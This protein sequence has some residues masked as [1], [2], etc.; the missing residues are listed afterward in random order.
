[1]RRSPG[2]AEAAEEPCCPTADNGGTGMDTGAALSVSARQT[3]REDVGDQQQ[4]QGE[5]SIRRRP[6]GPRAFGDPA[7]WP[8][9]RAIDL[10]DSFFSAS[11]EDGGG[12]GTID[13]GVPMNRVCLGDGAGNAGAGGAA[14]LVG[15]VHTGVGGL[16]M[17]G[18]QRFPGS[19]TRTTTP[20]AGVPPMSPD[21]VSAPSIN[22]GPGT[23]MGDGGAY[24]A[25]AGMGDG[26][27]YKA[28]APGLPS[29]LTRTTTSGAGVPPMS[30]ANVSAPGINPGPES[31]TS[32][33]FWCCL[34]GGQQWCPCF[35]RGG[36]TS[37]PA[38]VVDRSRLAKT[39]RETTNVYKFPTP[40]SSPTVATTASPTLT[41]GPGTT[42][43][44]CTWNSQNRVVVIKDGDRFMCSRNEC[45]RVESLSSAATGDTTSALPSRCAHAE[46][47]VEAER[48]SAPMRQTSVA[49]RASD[50]E[51]ALEKVPGK[52]FNARTTASMRARADQAEKEGLPLLV[53]VGSTKYFA[54]RDGQKFNR[55][56]IGE[57]AHVKYDKSGSKIFQCKASNGSPCS[58]SSSRK[59][60]G[61]CVHAAIV[62]VYIYNQSRSG[63]AGD[64]ME[65]EQDG[66]MDGIEIESEEGVGDGEDVVG[67][68]TGFASYT[69]RQ[70]PQ[71]FREK[72]DQ[73]R[74]I[75]A[76]CR[77]PV[78]EPEFKEGTF[79]RGKI[80]VNACFCTGCGHK[81]EQL[82]D[83]EAI[84]VGQRTNK[85]AELRV[86]TIERKR[87]RRCKLAGWAGDD[88]YE[89][90]VFNYNNN[91]VLE[92]PLLYAIRRVVS[93]GTPVST[94]ARTFLKRLLD[95]VRWLDASDQSRALAS[96]IED[97]NFHT[98]I[99]EAY[100]AFEA[101]TEHVHD[102]TSYQHGRF[103]EV[104]CI[105]GCA[106]IC[107]DD[108][109]TE[110]FE[111]ARVER[112]VDTDLQHQL[113]KL[114]MISKMVFE[115]R[116]RW[117]VE[118]APTVSPHNRISNVMH[119]TAR[120]KLAPEGAPERGDAGEL[121][122]ALGDGAITD[123]NNKTVDDLK[124][125]YRLCYPPGGKGIS[126]YPT[127][128]LL[129][130][131]LEQ[132]WESAGIGDGK[133]CS[134]IF[135][136]KPSGSTAG[137]EGL[138][139]TDGV[140]YALVFQIALE[141]A[142][143]AV[144]IIG[145]RQVPPCM[146]I[147]DIPCMIAP[148]A[149][150]RHPGL[151][152]GGGALPRNVEGQVCLKEL[153]HI[154]ARAYEFPDMHEVRVPPEGF[155]PPT[156]TAF[157]SGAHPAKTVP[158]IYAAFAAGQPRPGVQPH[159]DFRALLN[160]AAEVAE[161]KHEVQTAESTASV[162]RDLSSSPK[163][164]AHLAGVS[165]NSLHK[166]GWHALT[167][168]EVVLLYKLWFQAAACLAPE[169][170]AQGPT[171]TGL[172]L[173]SEPGGAD[174]TPPVRAIRDLRKSELLLIS[175]FLTMV[176]RVATGSTSE[177]TS[178][179]LPDMTLPDFMSDDVLFQSQPDEGAQDNMEE[180][181]GGTSP[182]PVLRDLGVVI[183]VYHQAK[184]DY[185]TNLLQ[186]THPHEAAR[187]YRLI[188]GGVGSGGAE[189]SVKAL[190]IALSGDSLGGEL[191]EDGT[192]SG[193][194]IS[195]NFRR[196]RDFD[197][198]GHFYD[199]K[200][201][202]LW[203]A[204]DGPH[205]GNHQGSCQDRFGGLSRC[206]QITGTNCNTHE[207]NHAKKS[208]FLPSVSGMGFDT[209]TFNITLINEL[210]NTEI[211]RKT[212][213]LAVASATQH[214]HRGDMKKEKQCEQAADCMRDMAAP[215]A[216]LFFQQCEYDMP[217]GLNPAEMGKANGND[218]EFKYFDPKRS[219]CWSRAQEMR[220]VLE[221][222]TDF[223]NSVTNDQGQ[224]RS[225]QQCDDVM[226]EVVE[227]AW[228]EQQKEAAYKKIWTA[229]KERANALKKWNKAV[230]TTQRAKI[231]IPTVPRYEDLA[232]NFK[233]VD[234]HWLPPY[235][236]AWVIYGPVSDNP[237]EDISMTV[238]SGPM[239][240]DD[241]GFDGDN[242]G[243]GGGG[244]GGRDSDD[245]NNIDEDDESISI[246]KPSAGCGKGESSSHS[247]G[248][249]KGKGKKRSAKMEGSG[250]KSSVRSRK[251]LRCLAGP[252]ESLSRQQVKERDRAERKRLEGAGA[253]KNELARLAA[254]NQAAL[255]SVS[256]QVGGMIAHMQA[257][258]AAEQR[259][260]RI[261]ELEKLES[262]YLRL[263]LEDKAKEVGKKLIALL[264]SEPE[265]LG[266][267]NAAGAAGL[268][269]SAALSVPRDCG[270]VD[271]EGD[272][273]SG[274][275]AGG[276]ENLNFEGN[277]GTPHDTTGS[278]NEAAGETSA[279]PAG[280]LSGVA[281]KYFATKNPK[282]GDQ[283][284]AAADKTDDDV[285]VMDAGVEDSAGGGECESEV[286]FGD[287][288]ASSGGASVSLA[289]G[290]GGVGQ[291]AT[292]RDGRARTPPKCRDHGVP[293]VIRPNSKGE[294]VWKCGLPELADQCWFY[295][296]VD[297]GG[298]DADDDDDSDF[299]GAGAAA[300]ARTRETL[301][302]AD[303]A[304]ST[305]PARS[306][307]GGSDVLENT[308]GS[309][310]GAPLIVDGA[311]VGTATTRPA[312]GVASTVRASRGGGRTA[313]G[314]SNLE[315]ASD[316]AAGA[317]QPGASGIGGLAFAAVGQGAT[318][319]DERA[320]TPPKC[321]DH[322]V[323]CVIR[324]N[325]KGED[326]WRCG[327]PA[328]D[329]RC[330][331]YKL[332]DVGGND[333]AADD[334]NGFAGAGA[335]AGA[336]IG[337]SLLA[338]DAASSTAPASSRVAG[339][340]VLENTDVSA[341]G[342]PLVVDDA[343]VGTATTMVRASSGAGRTAGGTSN[344]EGVSG[345][346]AGA[347]QP[348]TTVNSATT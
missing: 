206:P 302:A 235:W 266:G 110:H 252:N 303:A 329:E 258:T 316:V 219:T 257:G 140:L 177:S 6:G 95:D 41:S 339:S 98:V 310:A 54:V 176:L 101:L 86:V 343:V 306:R 12:G 330:W 313:G 190:Q 58:D 133:Q 78:A 123:L 209:F 126:K 117:V 320:R 327:L 326:V 31:V 240:S 217:R 294:D 113:L 93:A 305:A 187:A 89:D 225:G 226:G 227:M 7:W 269:I 242:G 245:E 260:N 213:N 10:S 56:V 67:G 112:D 247:N 121:Y 238:S 285:I 2:G 4:I 115:R 185:I 272:D 25:G 46:V 186:P 124:N 182:T 246:G 107:S 296:R 264:E 191:G 160:R 28:G 82:A 143:D 35:E 286:E 167:L 181:A 129:I 298:S 147:T 61:R 239:D 99:L 321:R 135:V 289:G 348:E 116:L 183:E 63:G 284:P 26:G 220:R 192:L 11:G 169:D 8:S 170:E 59:C 188:Q 70:D 36:R 311:A 222:Y 178:S 163:R 60:T 323:P 195:F 207:Q 223:Y 309:A 342:A 114:S 287:G 278:H 148:I 205:E 44:V 250:G 138:F 335:A 149:E 297:V 166:R 3:D 68:D 131:C 228:G 30:P 325:S 275:G 50:F 267:A 198:F 134:K 5:F 142:A 150:R 290:V 118:A 324:P 20:G 127:K 51:S 251:S 130:Q 270:S 49:L 211:N 144:D 307:I 334:D 132:L 19:M 136:G 218:K 331:F 100:F 274:A 221:G 17:A 337:T 83:G 279:V 328:S 301:P 151:L 253:G 139:G 304:S 22:P 55:T 318:S 16:G 212:C 172:E 204:P 200:R 346:G 32:E 202:G 104:L 84:L 203:L 317:A 125:I 120:G 175:A 338:A 322:D 262:R 80:H 1:M 62:A 29:A 214:P 332:V 102:F 347:A 234:D 137:V 91:V 268:P 173:G 43:S 156:T 108:V 236:L 216:F 208:K 14:L 201:V 273:D 38:T 18:A 23:G 293:C 312:R 271:V 241:G 90:G 119:R 40:T 24:M 193:F 224:P 231:K 111:V 106:K 128:E 265:P 159:L 71:S 94:W 276:A 69:Q 291:G 27:A 154:G 210:E 259:K 47:V 179:G 196:N 233:D 292:S 168:F 171:S 189:H 97:H 79:G 333:A 21:N 299:G 39:R 109:S 72:M 277:V 281:A 146:L 165:L 158:N 66:D 74:V 53:S 215:G 77:F 341:A 336:R 92:L 243:G 96:R 87:C 65:L 261:A 295:E 283:L 249:A 255:Q 263:G 174:D 314:T 73:L 145:H 345:A 319:R 155:P 153:Q 81:Y 13:S 288:E 164:I 248:K 344:V 229:E 282:V 57:W 184:V 9:P 45:R 105:D 42:Y 340:G 141:S 180:A 64:E 308:G 15:R 52:T 75:T 34:H 280:E 85:E 254:K 122:R 194:G 48:K 157:A 161:C 237:D 300:G 199:S 197:S 230:D 37:K 244:G 33:G 76:V 256:Q 88:M 315:G 162:V 232:A 152:Q 103:P